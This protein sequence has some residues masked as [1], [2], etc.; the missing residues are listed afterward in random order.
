MAKDATLIV[1]EPPC[2]ALLEK[3]ADFLVRHAAKQLNYDVSGTAR[4]RAPGEAGHPVKDCLPAQA[5]RE[6]VG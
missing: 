5:A 1:A 2:G 3:M 6:A 4:V